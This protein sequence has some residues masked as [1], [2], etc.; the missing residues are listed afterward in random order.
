M[1]DDRLLF[2]IGVFFMSP[3]KSLKQVLRN[4]AEDH[5]NIPPHQTAQVVEMSR[6]QEKLF[7]GFLRHVAA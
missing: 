7:D 6:T 3:I 1:R 2:F 5:S 4:L